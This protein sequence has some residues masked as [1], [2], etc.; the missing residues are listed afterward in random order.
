[1][2]EKIFV[3]TVAPQKDIC[4][5]GRT[6]PIKALINKNIYIIKPVDQTLV[7]LN[8]LFISA[9]IMWKKIKKKIN[10]T[11]FIWITWKIHP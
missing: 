10:D 2:A 11:K 1:M 8:E 9:F 3:I 4:P 6:Y 5:Q 7:F